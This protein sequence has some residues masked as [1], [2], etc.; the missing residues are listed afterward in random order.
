MKDTRRFAVEVMNRAG[1]SFDVPDV[2]RAGKVIELL[3]AE[4]ATWLERELRGVVV[5]DDVIAA[6]RSG[7][8]RLDQAARR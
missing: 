4:L 2:A 3:E 5:V 6:V 1:L 7:K 8:W